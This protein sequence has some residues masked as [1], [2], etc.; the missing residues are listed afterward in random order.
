MKTSNSLWKALFYGIVGSFFFAFTFI[1]NRSMNL[2]GGFWMYNAILRFTF[3]LLIL[4]CILIP[5]KKYLAVIKNIK[6]HPAEWFLWSTIGFGIFYLPVSAASIYAESW[7]T[8]SMWQITIVCGILLTPLFGKKIPIK[9]LLFSCLILVGILIMQ[10]P[11]YLSNESSKIWLAFLLL[12]IGAIAYPLGNRK[13]QTFCDPSFSTIQRVFGMTLCSMPFWIVCAVIAFFIAGPPSAGQ[14]IQAAGV[15]FTSGVLGTLCFFKGTDLVR[16]DMKKLAIVEATQCG[17][18]V[19]TLILGIIF[20]KDTVPTVIGWVGI[21]IIIIG[22]ILT[23][24][25]NS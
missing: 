18:V 4:F 17:E 11:Q 15:A 19:F 20:L 9:N 24:L 13:T 23:S 22:M 1:L 21:A 14:T 8:C 2:S 3:T 7:F 10:I 6:Q 16:G 5:G 12:V 25:V